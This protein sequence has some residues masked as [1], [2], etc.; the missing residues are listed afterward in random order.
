MTPATPVPGVSV[1][2][3]VPDG[4][5]SW[6]EALTTLAAPGVLAALDAEL[7]VVRPG[8][9]D[10]TVEAPPAL[11]TRGVHVVTLAGA[12][13]GD[14]WHRGLDVAWADVV[15]TLP[16]DQPDPA[17]TVRTLVDTLAERR[18]DLLAGRRTAGLTLADRI[19]AAA[20][21]TVLGSPLSDPRCRAVALR[22]DVWRQ[23]TVQS[24]T[25][26]FVA[27]LKHDALR[28]GFACGEVVVAAGASTAGADLPAAL[29][30][31]LAHGRRPLGT[32][33]VPP[34]T[35]AASTTAPADRS[36][37]GPPAAESVG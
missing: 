25:D 27:E 37:S 33:A 28:R 3:A 7:I 17:G 9:D 10:P 20:A 4:S 30:Q 36:A 23:L 15:V 31:L 1:V 8:S 19:V 35:T 32:A 2:L 22:H 5:P 16:A 18:L 14:L 6:P 12:L 34:S 29:R 13:E 11:A 21:R 24:R 26:T